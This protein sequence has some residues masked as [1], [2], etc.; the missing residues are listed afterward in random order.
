[1]R[2]SAHA[3]AA[4]V[5]LACAGAVGAQARGAQDA[6][7][8]PDLGGMT[9]DAAVERLRA[10]GLRS[11][12]FGG[13]VRYEPIGTGFGS[14]VRLAPASRV[15]Q[16]TVTIQEPEP[17]LNVSPG[18]AVA[19]GTQPAPGPGRHITYQLGAPPVVESIEADQS[20]RRL[21]VGLDT[22]ATNCGRLDHVDVALRDRWVLLRPYLIDGDEG[23][24]CRGRS[25]HRHTVLRLPEPLRGRPVLE[26]LREAPNPELVN[27][28]P[29]PFTYARPSPDGRS[30]AVFYEYGACVTLAGAQVT[31]RRDAVAIMLLQGDSGGTEVC[32]AILYSGI[33]LVQL[34]SPLGDRRIVDGAR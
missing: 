13:A 10:A 2:R 32:P 12:A 28:H 16:R 11:V 26:R 24:A 1:M 19:F 9:R 34:P 23:R 33:A 15:G 29:T 25:R 21:T 4:F 14:R 8:V 30:V 22:K 31:E 18:T 20:G 6:V 5:A 27:Q 17:G 7:A 3:V